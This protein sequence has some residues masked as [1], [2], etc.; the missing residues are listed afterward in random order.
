MQEKYAI[1]RIEGRID[2]WEAV[3]GTSIADMVSKVLILES[4]LEQAYSIL[5]IKFGQLLKNYSKI[6]YHCPISGLCSSI[7]KKSKHLYCIK[8]KKI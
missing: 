7:S 2:T 3:L 6:A 4:I 1:H 8:E 5:S